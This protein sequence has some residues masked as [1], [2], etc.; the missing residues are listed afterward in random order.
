M[1]E[2]NFS[3]YIVGTIVRFE[4][5]LCRLRILIYKPVI[6]IDVSVKMMENMQSRGSNLNSKEANYI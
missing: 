1:F 5:R 3:Y 6:C 2:S 4:V